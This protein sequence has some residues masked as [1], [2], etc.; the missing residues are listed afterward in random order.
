MTA[1]LISG[2]RK[3]EAMNFAEPS[4]SSPPEKPPGMKTIWLSPMSFAM[5]FADLSMASL[6]RLL[7][8]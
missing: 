1:S 8:T 7:M 6:E 4:G 5:S 3:K 2:F